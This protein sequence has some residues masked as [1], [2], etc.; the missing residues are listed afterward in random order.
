[1]NNTKP[2]SNLTKDEIGNCYGK[3]TV[4]EYAG[5]NKDH[6]TLW[7]C[8]CAC[9]NE[10]VVSGKNLRNG[11]TKS[12]GCIKLYERDCIDML[13]MKFGKLLVIE[14][15]DERKYSGKNNTPCIQWRC[16]CDCGRETIVTG[17]CLRNGSTKSCGCLN[18]EH[19]K[20]RLSL[21]KRK[22][23]TYELHDNYVTMYTL[24]NEPFYVD[25]EDFDYI[26]DICWYKGGGDYI[27][28]KL[29]NKHLRLHSYIMARYN[30]NVDGK[31][32]II[33]H[34]GGNKT[35]NDN[36]K[37]NLRVV[38]FQQNA[39]NRKKR[40]DNTSG[41]TGVS[42]DKDGQKWIAYIGDKVLGRYSDKDV[43]IQVR[44]QA[45]EKYFKEYSYDNSQLLAMNNKELYESED[46]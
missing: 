22:N 46:K 41:V 32:F 10:C 28:G 20:Q 4:I 30:D 5:K 24:K 31:N 45:E 40:S 8:K 42:W 7:K 11:N 26:K 27:Y 12:C 33:D 3:L 34:I 39:M 38:T 14:K 21:Q 16:K 35:R 9:G 15:I 25:L 2:F 18:K 36:R 29:Q 6:R 43:A 37:A 19:D 1:M 44:K 23:N 13:G 17:K